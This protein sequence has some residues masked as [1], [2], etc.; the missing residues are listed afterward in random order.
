VA[1]T[2]ASGTAGA[3]DLRL[4]IVRLLLAAGA[5][6]ADADRSGVTVADRIKSQALRDAFA[7]GPL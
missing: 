4:G 2:G 7:A 1:P 6:L 3:D 5:S